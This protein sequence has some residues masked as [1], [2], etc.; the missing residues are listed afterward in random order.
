MPIGANAVILE[1]PKTEAI[2]KS[3][4]S[5]AGDGLLRCPPM[6]DTQLGSD[7]GI[8]RLIAEE[9]PPGFQCGATR[10]DGDQAMNSQTSAANSEA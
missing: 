10:K 3:F 5:V 6:P 7:K 1:C 8:K 4:V 2:M 9:V